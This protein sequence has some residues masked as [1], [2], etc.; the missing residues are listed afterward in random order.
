VAIEAGT[1]IRVKRECCASRPRCKRCPAVWKRL[2][3]LGLAERVS[4]RRYLV[5]RRVRKRDRE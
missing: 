3:R 5:V 2:S 1:E 4:K